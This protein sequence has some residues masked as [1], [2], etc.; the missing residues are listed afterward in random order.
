MRYLLAM[1]RRLLPLSIALGFAATAC[2]PKAPTHNGYK[3]TQTKPWT[4]AKKLEW[5]DDFE[6]EV[7]DEV[8]YPKRRRARWYEIEVPRFGELELK[9]ASSQIGEPAPEFDLAFE[10]LNPAGRVLARADAE[11]DD[12]GEETKERTITELPAGIYRVHIYAQKR[13]DAAEFNLR[14]KFK[15][16]KPPD[17]SDFPAEVP[18]VGALAAVPPV[19]DAPPP[20]VR[21]PRCRGNRCRKPPPRREPEPEQPVAKAMKARIAGITAREGRTMIR[22]AAGQNRGIA[23]GWSGSVVTRAGKAISN[24]G[25]QITKVTATESY[26]SVRASSDAV[27]AAKYVRLRPPKE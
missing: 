17:E 25:F 13:T 20:I 23:V 6:A 26:A 2:G 8:S 1:H 10:V 15:P 12:A 14:L 3:P 19:D 21:R 11:E 9:L 16:L 27:N 7:D 22:I 24:G 4:K 18:Y 5:S